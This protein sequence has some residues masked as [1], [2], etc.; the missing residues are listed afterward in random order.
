MRKPS[1]NDLGIVGQKIPVINYAKCRGYKNAKWWIVAHEGVE[2]INGKIHI[3]P[4]LCNNCGLCIDKCPFGAFEEYQ[5]AFKVFIG[6]R[7]GKR[8]LTV[9]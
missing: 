3:N 5:Y 2:L 8:S 9:N 7:W 4:D 6:G 1:L